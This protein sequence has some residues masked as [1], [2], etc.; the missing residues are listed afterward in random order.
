MLNIHGGTQQ[1]DRIDNG[2]TE[3]PL[4]KVYVQDKCEVV[5]ERIHADSDSDWRCSNEIKLTLTHAQQEMIV[6]NRHSVKVHRMSNSTMINGGQEAFR[7]HKLLLRASWFI[8]CVSDS[9]LRG[10]CSSL[11]SPC[12]VIMLVCVCVSV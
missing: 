9:W 3:G 8:S 7:I 12:C 10:F 11:W 6:E 4:L 1:E 2:W 5:H